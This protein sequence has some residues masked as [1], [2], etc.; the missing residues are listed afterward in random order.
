MPFLPHLGQRYS[1]RIFA[2][3]LAQ[4]LSHLQHFWQECF[5]ICNIPDKVG[6]PCATSSPKLVPLQ[7][8]R[9]PQLVP[10]ATSLQ[11]SYPCNTL[12]A[13]GATCIATSLQCTVRNTVEHQQQQLV[14][15]DARSWAAPDHA[16]Q[17]V[18]SV[19]AGGMDR[20]SRT[21]SRPVGVTL[22]QPA[23][24][25]PCWA[26][27]LAF[28]LSGDGG[29]WWMAVRQKSVDFFTH[30]CS[31]VET[32]AQVETMGQVEEMGLYYTLLIMSSFPLP[33]YTG[34]GCLPKQFALG[35]D[36]AAY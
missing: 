9:H 18:W 22:L 10:P 17:A 8:P 23:R 30:S 14:L 27:P 32:M 4:V 11:S 12:I 34:S 6:V 36:T 7:H 31:L 33:Y 21:K 15:P 19:R 3:L 1:P 5:L 25:P 28:G 13:V 26:S 16:G 29:E 20:P 2:T 24:G 35:Q